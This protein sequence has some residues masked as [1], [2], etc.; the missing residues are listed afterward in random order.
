MKIM[1]FLMMVMTVL[2]SFSSCTEVPAEDTTPTT[3][4]LDQVMLNMTEGDMEMLTATVTPTGT[5]VEWTSS[6][7]SVA[8][9]MYGGVTAV[10]VGNATITASTSNASAQCLVYVTGSDGSTLAIKSS[11][12]Y[13]EIGDTQQ[14][15]Y[16]NVYGLPL[17]WTS[18]N[19]EAVTVDGEGVLTAVSGGNSTITLSSGAESVTC[20]VAVT[21][22]Y[23]EYVM[24]WSDEFDGTSLDTDTWNIEVNGNG[25][26]NNESQ[27]YT[28]REENLRVE[29]G[30]LV[31]QA[32]KETY[33]GSDNKTCSYT[34][35][36]INSMANK[37]FTYGKIEARISLPQGQG[38]WPA[39]WTLGE[40]YATSGIGWPRCGEIDIM[41]HVGSQPTKVICALHTYAANGS[42]GLNWSSNTYCDDIEGNFHTYAVEWVKEGYNGRDYIAFLFDGVEYA[43]STEAYSTM[44]DTSYWPY[45]AD[46]FIIFNIALG[47][48]M[49]GTIDDSIFDEDVMMKVDYVRVYQREGES[50]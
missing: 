29:D 12:V 27:Y 40:N 14:L 49:G 22:S 16:S 28:A 32:F 30:N 18:S 33:T 42:N 35:A 20:F 34:S 37:F 25:G 1:S 23:G 4:E 9:V 44:D 21:P 48:S 39:F 6:D 17:T 2:C 5:T 45:Q 13:L 36:R 50:F 3:I 8:T 24:V 10:G 46:Q 41:E 19:E 11:T 43:R 47:G 31:I 26:G 7:E 15:E 38:T